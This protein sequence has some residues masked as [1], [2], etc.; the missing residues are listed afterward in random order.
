M[1]TPHQQQA[2]HSARSTITPVG[3]FTLLP[4]VNMIKGQQLSASPVQVSK[5]P[6]K[7]PSAAENLWIPCFKYC[8]GQLK[9]Q[10]LKCKRGIWHHLV[11][12]AP[13]SFFVYL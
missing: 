10:Q 11:A 9:E 5:T 12:S 7:H 8:S 6:A 4:H 3:S 2:L 13:T 1:L